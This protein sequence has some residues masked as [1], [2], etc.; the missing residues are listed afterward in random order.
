[1]SGINS[2]NELEVQRYDSSNTLLSSETISTVSD[3]TD[4]KITHVGENGGYIIS[5]EGVNASNENKIYYEIFDA[6]GNSTGEQSVDLVKRRNIKKKKIIEVGGD[7]SFVIA[8]LSDHDS[9]SKQG[10]TQKYNA[11]GSESGDLLNYIGESTAYEKTNQIEITSVGEDGA[12]AVTFYGRNT[13]DQWSVY[14]TLV[15]KN[16]DKILTYEDGDT[17]N[18]TI[19][20]DTLADDVTYVLVTYSTG[21]LEVDGV[22]YESGSYISASDWS[23]A[24]IELLGATG[25]DYDLTASGI[26]GL[27]LIYDSELVI[28]A[29]TLLENDSDPDGDSLSITSVQDPVN[30]SV[31]LNP[32]DTITFT[33]DPNL[34]GTATFTY[35]ISDGNGGTD[36]ATTTITVISNYLPTANDD[37]S[38]ESNELTVTASGYTGTAPSTISEINTT[39]TYNQSIALEALSTGEM[40]QV[41]K[42]QVGSTRSGGALIIMN[43]NGSLKTGLIEFGTSSRAVQQA[44]VTEINDNG[45]FA[46]TW[47]ERIGGEQYDYVYTQTF[48]ANGEATS[49]RLRID[50]DKNGTRSGDEDLTA[51]LVDGELIVS[52]YTYRAADAVTTSISISENSSDIDYNDLTIN[53]QDKYQYD[54]TSSAGGHYVH[55][56]IVNTHLSDT[57]SAIIYNLGT[58]TPNVQLPHISHIHFIENGTTTIVDIPLIN[59]AIT[60][61]NTEYMVAGLN[62]AGDFVL[63]T[64]DSSY[65]YVSSQ[66]ISTTISEVEEVKMTSLGENGAYVISWTGEDTSGDVKIYYQ[67]FDASGTSLGVQEVSNTSEYQYSPYQYD[68]EE[69]GSD[70]SFV[71]GFI[72]DLDTNNDTTTYGIGYAQKYTI[73]GNEDGNRVT[74]LDED[75]TRERTL[76][77]Q[78]TSMGD[79][80]SYAVGFTSYDSDG[81]YGAKASFVDASGNLT[82]IYEDGDTGDFTIT[83]D[84]LADD[85]TY[86]L[87]KYS[88][89][90]LE[91]NGTSYASG[92]YIPV[93]DWTN[94]K[95]IGAIGADYDLT[96]SAISGLLAIEDTD[97][98]IN[99]SILLDNDTDQVGDSFTVTSVQNAV[100]G[101]VILN[102]DDTITFTPADNYTGIATFTYTITDTYGDS[103]TA[104]V[105]IT[106]ASV[107]DTPL[108]TLYD[109]HGAQLLVHKKQ[110]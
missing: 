27:I 62:A 66:T 100:N 68:I 24:D 47:L 89:G 46:I 70:G 11:D 65:T 97:L 35:T 7:G 61:S 95:L 106:V 96:A 101:S 74:I 82:P 57:V 1:V 34:N 81:T 67:V 92:S 4:I 84:T 50:D 53:S 108:L 38:W 71:I 33:P 77:L 80:D 43:T 17:G 5:W 105:S 12:Y 88:T 56:N 73:D 36:T 10:Y 48:N 44:T 55:D 18:F 2:S 54:L 3:I 9:S 93:S 31:V 94:V 75:G 20:T 99:T 78:I 21:S 85:V 58:N 32:D 102:A 29:S 59:I 83:T 45:E 69:V 79:D 98:I 40:V 30:G 107:N 87:V 25:N 90:S 91:A 16:A 15:D 103:D 6:D 23:S 109:Q 104:T 60:Q 14:T 13:S 49:N 39:N 110:D 37:D 86:V 19:T 72:S 63:N 41:I 28:D 76:S 26:S 51:F 52:H 64:Y 8:F 42:E 22:V